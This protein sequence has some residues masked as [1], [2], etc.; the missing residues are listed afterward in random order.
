MAKTKR[1]TKGAKQETGAAKFDLD[2]FIPSKF[3]IPAALLIIFI[4]LAVFFA[5]MYFG[6]KT[7]QSGDIVAMMS[8]KNYVQ[9]ESEHLWNPFIFCGLPSAMTFGPER[10]YDFTSTV[11]NSVKDFYG[12]I[13]SV[14]YTAATF[15]L[16][17]LTITMFFLVREL[18]KNIWISLFVSLATMLSTGFV[19]FIFIGHITKLAVLAMYPLIFLI[20]IKMQ[21]EFKIIYIL[22]LIVAVHI[23][24]EPMHVQVI[25]YTFFAIGIY[26]LY[27][28]VHSIKAKNKELTKNLVKSFITF[29]V[30][31]VIALLMSYD[32]YMQT[33]EYTPYST[34]GTKSL[35]ETETKQTESDFYE[36]A[37]NWSFSPGEVLTFIIPSFYGFGNSTYQGELT[38]NQPVEINTYFG[39]MPFV[40]V[41]MYMGVVIFVLGIYSIF[42]NWK[43]SFVRFLTILIAISLVISFGRTF[44]FF[45][46]LMFYYFPFFDKFRVPSMILILVQLSFPVLAGLGIMKIISLKNEKNIKWEKIIKNSAFIFTGIFVLSLLLSGPLS[47]WFS[48]RVAEAGQKGQQL[49]P[50]YEYMSEMFL[51]DLYIGFIFL[52]VIFWSAHFY[53]NEK[54]SSHLLIIIVA[55]VSI[56]DLWRIDYRAAQYKDNPEITNQFE[57]PAYVTE[58]KNREK[59]I[60]QPFRLLN[61][62]QDGTPGSLNGNQNYHVYFLLED[63]YGYS[64]I[65]PRTYQDLLDIVGPGNPTLWRMLNVKYIITDKPVNAPE[66]NSTILDEKTALLVNENALPRVYFINAIKTAPILEVLNLIKANAFDPK[67]TVY[68]EDETLNVDIPDSTASVNIIEYKNE[69]MKV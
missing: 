65:K 3:Q 22:I 7:F 47:E 15:H 64:G 50:L 34:R 31:I 29:A 68:L 9:Q 28:F 45:Y 42:M 61:I 51:S 52:S 2:K 66:F 25:F 18:T 39:Q 23:L 33:Y 38:Q 6:G 60:N 17:I 69:Y 32:N 67:E 56:I 58:I 14:P 55:A 46:D 8:H 59:E 10:W 44:S 24:F 37:T 53:L 30:A 21:K 48:S 20:L 5:P 4:L 19:V 35:L 40:D 49:K 27:Y 36:Y 16:L 54:L 41:A 26:F 62:K 43:N 63:F 13:F 57:P 11:Y 12:K 1:T